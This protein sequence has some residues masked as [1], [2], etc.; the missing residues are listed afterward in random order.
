MFFEKTP[1]E[2]KNP[3]HMTNIKYGEVKEERSG[4]TV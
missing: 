2:M 1:I 3:K 4:E